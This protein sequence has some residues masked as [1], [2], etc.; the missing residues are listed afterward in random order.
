MIDPEVRPAALDDRAELQRIEQLARAAAAELRG[1]HRWLAEHP[2]FDW[3]EILDGAVGTAPDGTAPTAAAFVA[4][5]RVE[6]AP[7]VTVGYGVV[8]RSD[9]VATVRQVF[10]EEPARELGFG[11][12]I[13]DAAVAWA[14]RTGCRFIEGQA[15]P[16]DRHTK[17][18]Y[19]RSGITARLITV[20]RAL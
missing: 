13:V 14:R 1:G 18:L 20:S 15:L 19:E 2:P 12:A 17:N 9:E 3:T 8:T 11:D 6:A 7:A 16:G 4:E 5:L 10:I